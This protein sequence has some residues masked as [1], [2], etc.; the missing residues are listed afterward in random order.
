MTFGPSYDED[1]D[2]ER[3]S[4]QMS[5]I[6]NYML[7][8]GNRGAWRTLREISLTLGYPESSVSAQLRHLRKERFGAYI[9][10]KQRRVEVKG[11]WEY[12]VRRPRPSLQLEMEV[13]G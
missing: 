1:I 3:V 4:D 8:E 5:R 6:R 13:E 2:G 7:L 12:Q 9:V 11:T 10:D